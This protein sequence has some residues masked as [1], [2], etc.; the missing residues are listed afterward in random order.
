M[1]ET[2]TERKKREKEELLASLKKGQT[3]VSGA[4]RSTETYATGGTQGE[5]PYA[6]RETMTRVEK[7]EE[8]KPGFTASEVKTAPPPKAKKKFSEMT[9][10]ELSKYKPQ[11]AIDKAQ[12]DTFMRRRKGVEN[13]SPMGRVVSK[14]LAERA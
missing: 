7:A 11:G 3:E 8:S 4:T 12:F 2:E 6:Q 13:S 5:K 10:D 14:R 9:E 1:A